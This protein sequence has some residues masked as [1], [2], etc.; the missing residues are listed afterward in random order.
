[1]SLLGPIIGAAGSLLGSGFNA[2]SQSNTNRQ[3]WKLAQYQ[4]EQNRI[5]QGNANSFNERMISQQNEYNSPS[6]QMARMKEAGLNPNLMY[7][8]GTVGNQTSAPSMKPIPYQAPKMQ[9]YTGWNLGLSDAVS[10]FQQMVM[11]K[12]QLK[13]M[14]SQ[15]DAVEA[16]IDTERIKQANILQSTA[17]S[18]YDLDLARDLR[19]SVLS[20]AKSNADAAYY[21]A[22]TKRLPHQS[23]T[24]D[25]KNS[26]TVA[27]Q[28][29]FNALKQS[30]YKN[31]LSQAQLSNLTAAT[32]RLIQT[33]DIEKFDQDLYIST[34]L[35]KRDALYTRLIRAAMEGLGMTG[36]IDKIFNPK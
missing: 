2:I 9:S 4:A 31:Q 23:F 34:G 3:N 10:Q 32:R 29:V 14:A 25:G 16:G 35:T 15:R 13:N 28:L 33:A 27:Q 5:L 1:M 19:N 17:R 22:E 24:F 26:Q 12:Q 7:G 36:S 6:A 8:Q 30:D 18:K 21:D 11:Q 20:T